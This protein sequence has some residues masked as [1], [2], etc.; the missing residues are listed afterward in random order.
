M[1]YT[2]FI[3]LREAMRDLELDVA[4]FSGRNGLFF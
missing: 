4:V 1:E 2:G 3:L